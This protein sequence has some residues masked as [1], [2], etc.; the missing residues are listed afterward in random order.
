MPCPQIQPPKIY[1]F[2]PLLSSQI[3]SVFRAASVV[4]MPPL[5]GLVLGVALEYPGIRLWHPLPT[6]PSLTK[7]PFFCPD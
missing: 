5:W 1:S 7:R 4:E 3:C 6:R 2:L